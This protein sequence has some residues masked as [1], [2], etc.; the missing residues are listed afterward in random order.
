MSFFDFFSTYLSNPEIIID[1]DAIIDPQLIINYNNYLK[2]NN[3]EELNT[4]DEEEH[5]NINDNVEELNINYNE[6]SNINNDE[7]EHTNIN[8][9]EYSNIN[10]YEYLN[11]NDKHT[12]INNDEDQNINNDEYWNNIDN[13]FLDN[14]DMN[15]ISLYDWNYSIFSDSFHINSVVK[16][17]DPIYRSYESILKYNKIENKLNDKINNIDNVDTNIVIPIYSINNNKNL[18]YNTYSTYNTYNDE[19]LFID[20]QLINNKHPIQNY[21]ENKEN[22]DFNNINEYNNSPNINIKESINNKE[23]IKEEIKEDY[24]KYY[25]LDLN[26][27]CKKLMHLEYVLTKTPSNIEIVKNNTINYLNETI[28]KYEKYREEYLYLNCELNIYKYKSGIYTIND[29]EKYII[30]FCDVIVYLDIYK[31]YLCEILPRYFKLLTIHYFSSLPNIEVVK[32]KYNDMCTHLDINTFYNSDIIDKDFLSY[33]KIDLYTHYTYYLDEPSPNI[34]KQQNTLDI[35]RRKIY[36]SI[37]NKKYNILDRI[38]LTKILYEYIEC[39][40]IKYGNTYKNEGIDNN[41]SIFSIYN[42]ILNLSNKYK[43]SNK[44]NKDIIIDIKLINELILLFIRL[45]VY[46]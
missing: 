34:Y 42:I 19:Y 5:L 38:Y 39:I 14:Y 28:I 2:N 6:H 21:K 46:I 27:N 41:N 12:N 29:I 44:Y 7:K 24:T 33:N 16:F 45:Y 4:N 22:K 3:V 25:N 37:N 10:N 18:D 35:I 15:N 36:S 31:Y 1:T 13:Y 23:E 11:N 20:D 17:Y 30:D 40:Y 43:K 26:Y 32:Y 8:N 9:D